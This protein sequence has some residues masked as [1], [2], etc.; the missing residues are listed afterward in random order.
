MKH[1]VLA[2]VF[3]Q[4]SWTQVAERANRDYHT[5][6]GRQRLIN[7][8]SD[9]GRAKRL[10]AD[11]LVSSLGLTEGAVVVDLGTGTGVLLPFL[12]KVVGPSGKVVA[13][14]IIPEF[15]AKARELAGEQKLTNVEFIEGDEK[16][17]HLAEDSADV[18]LAVDSYHH[19]NYPGEMLTALRKALRERGKLVIID[20]YKKSFQDPDHIRIEKEDV[21][22]EVEI[23]GFR[24][25]T[26][27]EHV[28]N[29]QY[30]L[31]FEKR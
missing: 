3:M 7:T 24:L 12:S 16:N 22:K 17:P 26:N 10:E 20:Y 25:V 21:V 2:L 30:R 1:F 6:E 15:L 14:D 31:V 28:P 13:E 11:K 27:E 18:V 19:F 9:P 5:Q 23:N 29:S 4:V 8:L